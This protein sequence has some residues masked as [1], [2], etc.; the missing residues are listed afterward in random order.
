MA[1]HGGTFTL[2]GDVYSETVL[3]AAAN[4]RS[5]IGKTH[6]FRVSLQGDRCTIEGIN[7]PWSGTWTRVKPGGVTAPQ[8]AVP[9]DPTARRKADIEFLLTEFGNQAGRLL[10]LKGVDWHK[11][12]TW[13]RAEAKNVHTDEDHLRLC[14]RLLA[15]LRDGHARLEGVRV[16]FPDDSAGRPWAPPPVQLVG[17]RDT[18]FILTA[19]EEAAAA[20]AVP[21]AVVTQI[22]GTPAKDWLEAK[23]DEWTDRICYSTQAP[24]VAQCGP[25]GARRMGGH[26]RAPHRDDA[27]R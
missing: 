23:V 24:R 15:R 11:V 4:T 8:P 21:G 3:W 26:A 9:L 14:Q 18:V 27:G 13:C 22:D 25:V 10:D 1:H 6:Q 2:E 7:N 5:L 19:S 16:T 20:G 12:S 17:T